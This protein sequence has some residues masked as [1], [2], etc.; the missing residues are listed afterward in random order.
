MNE[1]ALLI[2]KDR[3]G[4][5]LQT[6]NREKLLVKSKRH[7]SYLIIQLHKMSRL[8]D[9]FNSTCPKTPPVAQ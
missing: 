1:E 6:D 4:K 5:V 9:S 3:T 2:S 8:E 7:N